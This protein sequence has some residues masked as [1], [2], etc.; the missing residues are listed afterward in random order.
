MNETALGILTPDGAKR[1]RRR[2]QHVDPVL[3]NDAP[4]G[5]GVG[6]TDGFAFIENRRV[7]VEKR[8]VNDIR[9]AH[10]PA[11][12]GGCPVDITRTTSIDLRHAPLERN[13]TASGVA[14]HAFWLACGA[15]GIENV[16]RMIGW[17]GHTVDR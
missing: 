4:E 1:R 10:N 6:R 16:K 9:M 5:S 13:D 15:G 3:G 17:H 14:H 7:A 2:K 12:I 11:D 8:P